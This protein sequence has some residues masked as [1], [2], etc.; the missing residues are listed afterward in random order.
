MGGL[1]DSFGLGE[2]RVSDREKYVSNRFIV[3][4]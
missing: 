3:L 2:R 4:D 1:L